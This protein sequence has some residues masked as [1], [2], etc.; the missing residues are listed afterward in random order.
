MAEDRPYTWPT[1]PRVRRGHA[2]PS[3][4]SRSKPRRTVIRGNSADRL[5]SPLRRHWRWTVLGLLV[6]AVAA[7]TR[8]AAVGVLPPSITLKAFA[9]ATGT[10]ELVVGKNPSFT[11]SVPDTYFNNNPPRAYA[12]ADMVASPEVAK[13]VARAAG[14]PASKI[15]I[16]GP[17]WTELQRTQ[18]WATGP[19]RA[20]Q[21]I[22]EHH[23]YQISLNVQTE[24]P[25]WAPVIDVNTRAPSTATAARLA[26]A[27]GD[28]LNAYVRHLQ[29]ATGVPKPDR[30]DISQL[31]PVSVAPARTSQLASVG[32]FTFVAVFVLWCGIII[33]V[34]SLAR[35]LRDTA[36]VS[37]VRDVFD[38]SSDTGPPA[39]GNRFTRQ[40]RHMHKL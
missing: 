6:A 16:L 12:L 10:T 22:I 5:L 7:A 3:S 17:L 30:Y 14:L 34:S 19:K 31:V 39:V 27:V 13:Y 25:P 38:R 21:I 36:A 2:P 8:F 18:A 33:A 20:S 24:S 28:G 26:T 29:A 1:R 32:A 23:P 35:D 15:G 37:K 40:P 4:I 9:R 11:H